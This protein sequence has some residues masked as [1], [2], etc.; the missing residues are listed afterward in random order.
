MYGSMNKCCE[1][2]CSLLC[3]VFSEV[4]DSTMADVLRDVVSLLADLVSNAILFPKGDK[5]GEISLERNAHNDPRPRLFSPAITSVKLL[6]ACFNISVSVS[7]KS[8]SLCRIKTC[9]R[10]SFIN[11]MTWFPGWAVFLLLSL[12]INHLILNS[13]VRQGIMITI[14]DFQWRNIRAE[15]AKK[16]VLQDRV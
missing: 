8:V 5:Q 13:E 6:D 14:C 9:S 1:H 3:H 11:I 12:P 4:I 16:H 2:L 10:F 15:W 7:N